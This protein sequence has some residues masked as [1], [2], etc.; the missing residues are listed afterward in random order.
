MSRK[1][2]ILDVRTDVTAIQIEVDCATVEIF[3]VAAP[4]LSVEYDAD[5]TLRVGENGGELTVKQGKRL[6]SRLYRSPAVKI[7]VP[8]CVVP[9]VTFAGKN[10]TLTLS[11]GIYERLVCY[12]ENGSVTLNGTALSQ[13]E[14]KGGNVEVTIDSAT[15][16][17]S[18]VCT[19]TSGDILLEN[20]FA[21]YTE[22][23]N[24]RG[25]L[26]A[27]SLN[28]KDSVFETVSGNISLTVTGKESGYNLNL[29]AVN[30]TCN[31]EERTL[32]DGAENTLKAYS[33]KGNIVV[34]FTEAETEKNDDTEK[35]AKADGNDHVAE[36]TGCTCGA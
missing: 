14:I 34:D 36:D 33:A 27:V 24:K 28:C 31:H 20:T 12:A 8:E 30:G 17:G 26:G 35:E 15:V 6:F 7:A 5:K 22:C 11:E 21:L 2:E 3:S 25:N 18:A 9:S 29:V 1:T 4:N 19:V 10:A 13:L 32:H 23:R 16:K